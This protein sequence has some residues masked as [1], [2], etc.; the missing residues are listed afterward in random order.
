MRTSIVCSESLSYTQTADE[1][2]LLSHDGNVDFKQTHVYSDKE[3]EEYR[4][5]RKRNNEA[6][7][8]ARQKFN[9]KNSQVQK[10][11]EALRNENKILILKRNQ[12]RSN[13]ELMKSVYDDVMRAT[14]STSNEIM[15][16]DLNSQSNQTFTYPPL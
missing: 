6:V 15:D 7:K 3:S 2:N 11:L 9:V 14:Q 5:K 12:I 8:K 16:S 10:R 1:S 13:Y 4:I